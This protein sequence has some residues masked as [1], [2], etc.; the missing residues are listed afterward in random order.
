MVYFALSYIRSQA[1]G[2]P[3]IAAEIS[4]NLMTWN[5]GPTHTTEEPVTDNLDGT[6]TVVVR[7][8]A[9]MTDS[10]QD[11]MRLRVTAN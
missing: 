8:I 10:P 11:F 5:S 3:A 4:S 9:P 1:P 6:D 7:M 2:T